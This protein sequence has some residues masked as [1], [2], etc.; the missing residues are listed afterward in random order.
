MRRPPPLPPRLHIAT[1]TFS[2]QPASGETDF[3]GLVGAVGKDLGKSFLTEE[4]FPHSGGKFRAT[5]RGPVLGG[6]PWVL[7]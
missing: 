4:A 6:K 5:P 7:P 3:W 2:G 1:E